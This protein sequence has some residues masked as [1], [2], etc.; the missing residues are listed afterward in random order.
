MEPITGTT[1]LSTEQTF[2]PSALPSNNP[3]R[4]ISAF[5]VLT[6]LTEL[7]EPDLSNHEHDS[8]PAH[9]ELPAY[10]AEI[11]PAYEEPESQTLEPALS[12]CFYQIARKL[13]IIT[14]ATRASLN[15]PRY[16]VTTRST[17]SLFSKKPGYTL[18]RLPS[19]VEA[20]VIGSKGKDVA[21]M[22]FDRNGELPWMP[23]ATV[24][25]HGASSTKYPI[26]A[27][28]FSDWKL[29]ANGETYK[30]LLG[31][32]PISLVLL[33]QSSVTIVARFTYSMLGTTASRG[34]EV[35]KMDFFEG[36][37]GSL[38]DDQIWIELVFA[39]C[40]IVMQH[41]K[42]M[43]RHYKNDV[44]PSSASIAGHRISRE[45]SERFRRA[46]TFL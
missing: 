30:W 23:R 22:N 10:T 24:A 37:S 46:S 26:E 18:T 35:G 27:P 17:A 31:E 8:P 14:P 19:S 42:S 33:K 36:F 32:D 12:F 2:V 21:T 34:A 44:T 40:I 3:F 41:W 5:E 16:R 38:N 28:N 25:H 43:G 39:T 1:T 9:E 15:R 7:T 45:A 4:R 11:A 29:N 13:Q 6:E 20:A